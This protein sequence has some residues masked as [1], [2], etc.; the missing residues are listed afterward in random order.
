MGNLASASLGETLNNHGQPR[1]VYEP[2]HGSAPDIAGKGIANPI[3][4]I[5]STAMLLRLS[6]GL[7]N[8]ALA[9]EKAINETISG[10]KRTPDLG[11]NQSTTAIT[12]EIIE[13]LSSFRAAEMQL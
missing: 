9:V 12:E 4:T 2:I 5:L 8:E 6:L 3:G 11:G 10:G 7:E 1:G 13:N